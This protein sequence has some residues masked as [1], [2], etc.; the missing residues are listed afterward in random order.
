MNAFEGGPEQTQ[1]PRNQRENEGYSLERYNKYKEEPDLSPAEES[2]LAAAMRFFE[3]LAMS[4]GKTP[5]QEEM[6]KQMLTTIDGLRLGFQPKKV[7]E[8]MTEFINTKEGQLYL[9]QIEAERLNILIDKE[10]AAKSEWE[11]ARKD[12]EDFQE[13][14]GM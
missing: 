13:K 10:R 12:V 14:I 1:E 5:S 9:A 7:D 11:K 4:D 3:K 6:L 8:V 2:L